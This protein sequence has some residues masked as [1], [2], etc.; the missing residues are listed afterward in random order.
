MAANRSSPSN[1]KQ[2]ARNHRSKKSFTRQHT[3]DLALEKARS[4]FARKHDVSTACSEVVFNVQTPQA[5]PLLC[6]ADYMSWAMQRVFERGEC[7]YYDFI[8]ERIELV[9]DLYDYDNHAGNMNFYTPTHPLRAKN[10]LS[11]PTP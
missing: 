2:R 1:S 6:V 3:L 7:R 11:P 4:R 10:K 5:E 9:V 8:R